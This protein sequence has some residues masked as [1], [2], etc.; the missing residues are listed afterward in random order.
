MR[1]IWSGQV[2]VLGTADKAAWTTSTAPTQLHLSFKVELRNQFL[3][4]YLGLNCSALYIYNEY[5]WTQ[6]SNS[7]R[8]RIF[9][10]ES[11]Y[12]VLSA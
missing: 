12:S 8:V 7:L 6:K 4:R 3:L 1:S 10:I 5:G 9:Y 11:A 2:R